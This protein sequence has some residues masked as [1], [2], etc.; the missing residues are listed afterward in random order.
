M[1]SFASCAR[2]NGDID[3]LFSELSISDINEDETDAYGH[4]Y[5]IIPNGCSGELSLKARELSNAIGEKT[6]IFTSLKYDSELSSPPNDSL[7]ILLGFTNRLASKDAADILRD[8]DYICRFDN[9]AI[10]IC[11]RSDAATIEGIDRFMSDVLPGMT[12]G[13]IMSK[14]ACIEN[15]AEYDISKIV[16]QGYDL[17]DYTIVYQ[18][19]SED[20][21]R[22]ALA[23]RDFINLKSGYFLEVSESSENA[24]H[25]IFISDKGEENAIIPTENGITV[26]ASNSYS[27]SCVVAKLVNDI[28]ESSNGGVLDLKYPSKIVVPVEERFANVMFY[29]VKKQS[30]DLK[31]TYEIFEAIDS[32][33]ADICFIGN[34]D[35]G[36]VEGLKSTFK[37]EHTVLDLELGSQKITLIYNVNGVKNL[38]AT[39]NADLKVIDVRFETLNGERMRALYAL[40]AD[41]EAISNAVKD[42]GN[43]VVFFEGNNRVAEQEELLVISSGNAYQFNY[44]LALC[45]NLYSK[46][47]SP[48]VI[49]DAYRFSVR[50][51][52]GARYS[53]EFLNN[54][55]K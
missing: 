16:L 44:S 8:G 23:L 15:I 47:Q 21:E 27:L 11:G 25:R 13:Y 52:L 5:V 34:S 10:V 18:K 7:E 6:G 12:N 48:A 51:E 2:N 46:N 39:V 53:F 38:N 55:L 20:A 14:D 37:A 36:I 33:G 3:G 35:G 32:T 24:V 30:G 49:N 22:V 1:A 19:N 4:I 50:A 42:D 43:T 45:E 40:N 26:S 28:K 9:G 29:T 17:Y 31:P 54:A 41:A